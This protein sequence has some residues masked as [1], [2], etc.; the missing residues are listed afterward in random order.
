MQLDATSGGVVGPSSTPPAS[1]SHPPCGDPNPLRG[2]HT[3][4]LGGLQF[5][6]PTTSLTINKAISHRDAH[7]LDQFNGLWKPVPSPHKRPVS[8]T[9]T[10]KFYDGATNHRHMAL[11]RMGL[12]MIFTLNSLGA[13]MHSITAEATSR[14]PTIVS[15]VSAAGSQVVYEVSGEY[16]GHLECR[17][18][19]TMGSQSPLQFTV[20]RR[21]GSC[22]PVRLNSFSDGS[23][24]LRLGTQSP[25]SLM[26]R[27][28]DDV[29][30]LHRPWLYTLE[31][32]L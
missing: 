17:I 10:I 9:G 2:I 6:K 12:G 15:A 30:L 1:G 13:G 24:L 7:L 3:V 18:I 11:C 28:R 29:S 21:S 32:T 31:P 5:R 16:H 4:R 19:E 25:A 22:D 23:T 26:H 27:P 8:A 14:L 20:T